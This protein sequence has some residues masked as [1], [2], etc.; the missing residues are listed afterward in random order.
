MAAFILSLVTMAILSIFPSSAMAVKRGE[1]QLT[2]DSIAERELERLREVPFDSLPLGP[3][4][5]ISDEQHQGTKYHLSVEVLKE[6]S[7][8]VKVLKRLVATVTWSH[9]EKNY[10]TV[11][12][13]WV[14]SVHN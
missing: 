12:E 1:M 3:R 5:P 4:P 11:H 10:S 6:P 13:A 14:T 7:S 2:A 9:S 8:D